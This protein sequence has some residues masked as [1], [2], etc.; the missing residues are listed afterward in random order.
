MIYPQIEVPMNKIKD[1]CRKWKIAYSAD[2]A[3]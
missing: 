2:F 3:M 1:F